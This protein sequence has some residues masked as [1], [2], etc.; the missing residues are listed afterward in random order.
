MG[1]LAAPARHPHICLQL[2][3]LAPI[4]PRRQSRQASR[5]KPPREV[6][7]LAVAGRPC[8]EIGGASPPHIL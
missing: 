1:A 4:F 7:R 2:A 6:P 3:P 8:I 5:A